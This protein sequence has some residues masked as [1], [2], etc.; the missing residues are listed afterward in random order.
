MEVFLRLRGDALVQRIRP[1]EQVGA[2]DDEVARRVPELV[3]HRDRAM[4]DPAVGAVAAQQAAA[5]GVIKVA[6]VTEAEITANPISPI[7]ACP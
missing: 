6:P 1:G 7:S 5:M 2:A 3:V 4:V